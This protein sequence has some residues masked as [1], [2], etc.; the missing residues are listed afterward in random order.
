M[1]KIMQGHGGAID[2]MGMGIMLMREGAKQYNLVHSHMLERIAALEA[3][4]CGAQSL[5]S[6]R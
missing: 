2:L 4:C 1:S 3:A 5:E 6:A